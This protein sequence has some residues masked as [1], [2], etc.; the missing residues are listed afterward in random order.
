MAHSEKLVSP[1]R[2]PVLATLAVA[3]LVSLPWPYLPAVRAQDHQGASASEL[4]API[5]TAIDASPCLTGYTVAS[6]SPSSQD[7][8]RLRERWN[9]AA[10]FSD[11]DNFFGY[12]APFPPVRLEHWRNILVMI[13]SQPVE[14][15]L[16]LVNGFFNSWPSL[17]D[18]D[19][20][21]QDD[22]WASPEEFVR[23]NGGDCEDYAL[24][25][26]MALRHLP[27]KIKDMWL[28]LGF[29]TLRNNHHA[30]LAVNT[31]TDIFILDNLSKPGYL[32]IPEKVFLKNFTP[33]A[34]I[35]NKG[36]WLYAHPDA[37]KERM[38]ADREGK[39]PASGG[40]R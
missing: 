18:R 30:V 38:Q 6:V 28:L 22:Y 33:F 31:G 5:S 23:R 19:N 24:I 27:V 21:G 10:S 36:L 8:A 26:Y 39:I 11:P 15:A 34:A 20:Y 16:R 14:K 3:L 2:I 35:N 4:P 1:M 29:N 40:K 32:L 17:E 12:D 7:G 37:D 13:E 9:H 25:K